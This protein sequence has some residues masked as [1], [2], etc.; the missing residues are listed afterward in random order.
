MHPRSHNF[1]K[2]NK[3]HP[4]DRISLKLHDGE[5]LIVPAHVYDVFFL[6]IIYEIY[7]KVI[8]VFLKACQ[9]VTYNQY[10]CSVNTELA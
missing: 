2:T 10:E 5:T 8:N 7:V 3:A 6:I 1:V 9:Y 4:V